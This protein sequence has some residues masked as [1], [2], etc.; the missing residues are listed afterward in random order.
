MES[1]EEDVVLVALA[2]HVHA[3][4]RPFLFGSRCDA[5]FAL[6]YQKYST[7]YV[8]RESGQVTDCREQAM[9]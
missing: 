1:A 5:Y 4:K 2:A 9:C 8:I 3:V 7:K 6:Y